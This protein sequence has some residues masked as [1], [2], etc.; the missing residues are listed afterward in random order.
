MLIKELIEILNKLSDKD[1]EKAVKIWD[2]Q[3]DRY[4]DVTN[5]GIIHKS[6]DG[7]LFILLD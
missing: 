6:R 2:S 7:E 1:K 3:F 5:V 4:V